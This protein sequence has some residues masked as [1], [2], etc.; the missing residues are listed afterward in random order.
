MSVSEQEILASPILVVDDNPANVLLLRHILEEEGYE[1]VEALTD[2]GAVL[3]MLREQT[4]DLLLL[5]IRMPSPD[6][7]EILEMM[8]H[9]LDTAAAPPVLVLTAQTDAETR[10]RALTAGARDFLTKPFEQWEVLLRI[11]NMLEMRCLHNRER[12]RGDRLAEEVD[13]RTRQ[14]RET[15]LEIIRRLGRAGEYRDN[16]TGAHVIRMSRI[17]QALALE[18]GLDKDFAEN[19]LYASPMHDIGK[20]GVPDHILLKPGRLDAEEWRIMQRHVDI[21]AEILAGHSSDLMQM[22]HRI[23]LSHHEKWDGSGYPGGLAG[24]DIPLEGR[25]AAIA[26]VFDALT[27]VRP[28][29]RAWPVSEAVALI[30]DQAGRHFDP[31]LVRMF[32]RILPEIERIRAEVPDDPVFETIDPAAE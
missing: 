12:L 29:K 4:V 3:P 11:R 27:S 7:I 25:I 30:N 28:Y 13:R 19:L 20:I 5:D 16:E 6:G 14:I 21:G 10:Q 2:S 26:D 24:T 18:A 22:A 9:D 15:Q 23:A 8:R 32:N 1:R 17:C 31:D